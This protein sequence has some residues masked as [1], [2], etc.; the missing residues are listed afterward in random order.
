MQL[1]DAVETENEACLTAIPATVTQE[2]G[3]RREDTR[4]G[5]KEAKEKRNTGGTERPRQE[6]GFSHPP[7]LPRAWAVV[8]P[9]QQK[10]CRRPVL[11]SGLGQSSAG[12]QGCRGWVTGPL[13]HGW[14]WGGGGARKAGAG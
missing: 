7:V 5:Q 10:A 4:Q 14:G 6:W 11:S 13:G 9:A 2:G 12:H 1:S 8:L 3:M